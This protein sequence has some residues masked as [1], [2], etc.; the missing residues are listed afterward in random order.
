MMATVSEDIRVVQRTKALVIA[1]DVRLARA[2]IKRNVSRLPQTDGRGLVADLLE[3]PSG[4]V[5]GIAV[6]ALVRSVQGVGAHRCG[7]W[8]RACD[9][10]SLDTKVRD[11]SERQR[12]GLANILRA[13]R[14]RESAA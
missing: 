10:R 3:Y 2:Q 8:L 4:H 13:S 5:P 12:L 1:N 11:L 9:V 7:T 14:R 6:G